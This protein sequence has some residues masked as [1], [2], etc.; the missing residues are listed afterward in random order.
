MRASRGHPI[1]PS[2]TIKTTHMIRLT[3]L[4][5]LGFVLWWT[6]LA[7]AE[8]QAFLKSHCYECHNSDTQEG[9]LDLTALK[10]ELAAPENFA[11]W[12]KIHDRIRS[13]EMPPKD[14][15]RPPAAVVA[16]VSDELKAQLIQ[17]EQTQRA[18]EGRRGLRRMTRAEYENTIRDL[19]DMPGIALAGGGFKHGQHLAFDTQ[20]NYPLSNLYVSMLQ[21]LGIETDIFSTGTGTLRGLEMV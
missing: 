3:S 8:P 16:A 15:P 10:L 11:R 2:R 17:A 1:T 12:V 20:N 4:M 18:A 14:Q 5:I 19:F 13:G 6:P 7:Q 21:R 9:G